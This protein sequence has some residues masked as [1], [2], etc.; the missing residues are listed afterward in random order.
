L[1]EALTRFRE[2]GDERNEARV[3]MRP[4]GVEFLSGSPEGMLKWSEQALPSFRILT[5][6]RGRYERTRT[7]ALRNGAE[8]RAGV[9][10]AVDLD[11]LTAVPALLR[12]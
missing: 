8:Y 3:L 11:P 10:T 4:G 5:A 1:T 7:P 6:E 2:A 9:A 12:R